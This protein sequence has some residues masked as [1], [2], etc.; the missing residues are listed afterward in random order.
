MLDDFRDKI[1]GNLKNHQLINNS[2]CPDTILKGV[3][4]KFTNFKHR[5]K[6]ISFVA[7]GRLSFE[8]GFLELIKQLKE[9]KPK[10]KWQLD[11]FGEG[12]QHDQ[13]S[14]LI[15]QMNLER[16]IFLKGKTYFLFKMVSATRH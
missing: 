13:L 12:P 16:N 14:F 15:N 1:G 6:T 3:P 2:V 8:K 11:I 7:I 10:T 5:E 4:D 9:F